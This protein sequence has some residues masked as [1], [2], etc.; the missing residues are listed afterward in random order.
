MDGNLCFVFPL[1]LY[2]GVDFPDFLKGEFPLHLQ[3]KP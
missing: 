1:K 2:H 3:K